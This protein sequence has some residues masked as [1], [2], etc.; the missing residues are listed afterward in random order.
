MGISAYS[1]LAGLGVFFWGCNV[2]LIMKRGRARHKIENE[3][4]NTLKNQ[5]Y[6]FEHIFGHSGLL[7]ATPSAGTTGFR[8]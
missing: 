6:K 1:S 7:R 2:Y 5:R 8:F 3:T 4:I